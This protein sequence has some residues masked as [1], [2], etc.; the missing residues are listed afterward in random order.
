MKRFCS[1]IKNITFAKILRIVVK[2]ICLKYS[3]KNQ[4]NMDEDPYPSYSKL[5]VS[6]FP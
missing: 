4:C 6:T 3:F 1:I 2:M 5:K